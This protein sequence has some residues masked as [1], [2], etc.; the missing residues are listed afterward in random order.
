[1]TAT[2]NKIVLYTQGTFDVPNPNSQQKAAMMAAANDI[3]KSGF[4]TVILGQWHVHADGGIYYNDSLLD[5]VSQNLQTIV[6][7]LKKGGLRVLLTFGPFGSDFG[8]IQKNEESFKEAIANLQG[9]TGI[10]G[11]DWDLEQDYDEYTALLVDLTQWAGS[12]ALVVTAAPYEE[13]DFW[14]NVLKQSPSRFA[15]WNLQLY[16]GADYGDWVGYLKGKVTN[17]ETFL[18][19]GF[20]VEA[21]GAPSD[22]Q[23][24]LKQ[25]KSS[26]PSLAGASSG[27]TRTWRRPASPQHNTP[28][29]FRPGSAARPDHWPNRR[30]DF[31]ADQ[32]RLRS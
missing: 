15:W 28:K 9:D 4:N 31:E 2:P 12:R 1:M 10:Q 27:S 13:R 6:P 3:I 7:A 21:G 18:V 11:L 17:P 14:L 24:Q 8:G 16:G 23:S 26:Y 29:R 19:P 32:T 22:V 25:M 5:T 30:I 20:K